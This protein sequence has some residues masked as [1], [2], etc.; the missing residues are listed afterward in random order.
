MKKTE[1]LAAVEALSAKATVRAYGA[2]LWIGRAAAE[3]LAAQE[4]VSRSELRSDL[5]A[6]LQQHKNHPSFAPAISEALQK[7]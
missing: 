4:S 1:F 6:A 3:R 5:E 7:L 2:E